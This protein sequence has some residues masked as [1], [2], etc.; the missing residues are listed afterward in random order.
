MCLYVVISQLF[1]ERMPRFFFFYLQTRLSLHCSAFVN[2][3]LQQKSVLTSQAADSKLA[4][5][6]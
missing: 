3:Y 1:N 2:K 5:V 4:G 6:P